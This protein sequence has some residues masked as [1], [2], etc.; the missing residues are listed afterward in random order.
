MLPQKLVVNSFLAALMASGGWLLTWPS[1]GVAL[2]I[3]SLS[4]PSFFVLQCLKF[5]VYVFRCDK[6][7]PRIHISSTNIEAKRP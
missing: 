4:P 6:K 3:Q 1:L 7:F 2:Y 5:S